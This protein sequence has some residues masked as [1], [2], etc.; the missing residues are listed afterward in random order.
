MPIT[1]TMVLFPHQ[2]A[3]PVESNSS[4][5][6]FDDRVAL[7][8]GQWQLTCGV[9]EDFTSLS[10]RATLGIQ[11]GYVTGAALVSPLSLCDLPLRSP[12][13][14]SITVRI[15]SSQD[16]YS[17]VRGSRSRSSTARRSA[18]SPRPVLPPLLSQL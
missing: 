18:F 7:V 16:L 8:L 6:V 1:H 2:G 3:R 12:P 13:H 4:L 11:S 5:S 10:G 14:P 9:E 17:V 15:Q